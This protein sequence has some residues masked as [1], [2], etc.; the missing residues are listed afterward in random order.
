MSYFERCQDWLVSGEP[1]SSEA[2]TGALQGIERKLSALS[3]DETEDY[4]DLECTLELLQEQLE[5]LAQPEAHQTPPVAQM[6][7]DAQLAAVEQPVAPEPT[8][9]LQGLHP[10]DG[11]PINLNQQQKAQALES[12]LNNPLLGKGMPKPS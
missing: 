2:L 1:K 8:L 3:G 5:L 6:T 4:Q 12:L 11:Q 10:L 9:D 7:P